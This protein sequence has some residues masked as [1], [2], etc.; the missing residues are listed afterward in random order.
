MEVTQ[1]LAWRVRSL[2]CADRSW[3]CCEDMIT[4]TECIYTLKS[5]HQEDVRR[6]VCNVGDETCFAPSVQL[7]KKTSNFLTEF[8]ELDQ[9]VLPRYK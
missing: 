5:D 9:G 8:S 4:D 2:D 7:N 3:Q 6:D 1:A